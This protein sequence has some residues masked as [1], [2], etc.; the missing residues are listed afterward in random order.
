MRSPVSSGTWSM[1]SV[2]AGLEADSR[3]F[4]FTLGNSVRF[5]RQYP[6]SPYLNLSIYSFSW[7]RITHLGVVLT[8]YHWIPSRCL[9]TPSQIYWLLWH[10]PSPRLIQQPSLLCPFF[11]SACSPYRSFVSFGKILSLIT[12]VSYLV[13]A[14]YRKILELP[15]WVNGV[16]E[17]INSKL[18]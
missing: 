5:L 3:G 15:H 7:N 9:L 14:W 11:C 8:T 6:P 13:L 10:R 18:N 1:H 16:R 17:E 4:K 2:G 12:L